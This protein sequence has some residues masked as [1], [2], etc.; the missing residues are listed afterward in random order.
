MGRP[1]VEVDLVLDIGDVFEDVLHI[2]WVEHQVHLGDVQHLLIPRRGG[3][4]RWSSDGPPVRLFGSACKRHHID[5]TQAIE[6]A[7]DVV[8]IEVG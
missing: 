2:H 5:L 4:S 7:R 1:A 8:Q 3:S 6:G